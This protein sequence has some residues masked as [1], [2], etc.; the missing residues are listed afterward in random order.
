M[1]ETR[2]TISLRLLLKVPIIPFMLGFLGIAKLISP[3]IKIRVVI[4]EPRFF[5]H[6]ALE[7]EVFMN[8]LLL[9]RN[10]RP[11]VIQF[12][13]LGKKSQASN[14][15]LWKI[16]KKSLPSLPSWSVSVLIALQSRLKTPIVDVVGAGYHRLNFL[17]KSEPTLPR[18][19]SFVHRR[20]QILQRLEEPEKP[21]VI[22]TVREHSANPDLRNRRVK[23]FEP[24][25]M[26]LAQ[27]GYNIV[28]LTSQ[29][30]DTVSLDD[31]RVLD[32]QTEVTG[33]SL[34]ELALVAGSRFVVSSTT[35]VDCLALAYR[36]PV[37]YVDA[38]RFYYM[39]LGTELATILMPRFVHLSDNEPI[40]LS[41][42][43]ELGLGWV[44]DANC[45]H[46][47][48][49]GI[50]NS[51]PNEIRE[52]VE[53]FSRTYMNSGLN[54]DPRQEV[55][56][57]KLLSRHSDEVSARHGAIFASFSGWFLDHHGGEFVMDD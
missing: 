44:K 53:H 47:N 57:H 25:M 49:V 31:P 1:T 40:K 56:K 15:G 38:A 34:D 27:N 36:R 2:R 35:G 54:S 33:H 50:V 9:W 55:W 12:C 28:R 18:S 3:Y 42:L 32:Y 10:S 7:P 39:F 23:D 8:D 48:G 41:E 19:S 5:G 30:V 14:I 11:R 52:C 6:L 4:M 13:T 43:L 22:F 29:T 51:S 26:A 17:T 16:R 46:E 45:F 20:N 37:L 21:Y 24:S